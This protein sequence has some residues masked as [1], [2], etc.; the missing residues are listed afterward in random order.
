M[1]KPR[2]SVVQYLNTAPLVWGMRHGA[3]RDRFDLSFTTPARCADALRSGEADVGIIPSIEYQRIAGLQIVPGVS[4]ASKSV[5]KSVLLLSNRPAEEIESV[6]LDTSSR[7]SAALVEIL[8]RKFYGRPWRSIPL[9]PDP[10]AMLRQADAALLI[11]DPALVYRG[12]AAHV[13]DLASEWRK[14][15]G[16][17]FVFA[18]WAGPEKARLGE[19]V[20]AFL[21][22]RDYGVAHVDEIAA[23]YASQLG[24][25]AA[26][27]RA[28]LTENINYSLDEENLAG[29]RLFYRLATEMGLI[30]R[31]QDLRFV[32]PRAQR[33]GHT[34]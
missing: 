17:P 4:I 9:D 2:I 5:V 28:Y 7:T 24:L 29:L 11:G 32:P 27:L 30:G 13:Y 15:T 22:S 31:A 16:L 25:S 18:L 33:Q 19:H 12:P 23:E 10:E 20:E 1:S 34:G 21:A 14:F 26:D 3:Q 8:L 6:A